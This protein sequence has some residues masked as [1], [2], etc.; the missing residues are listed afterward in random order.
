MNTRY[1]PIRRQELGDTAIELVEEV[2]IRRFSALTREEVRSM[3]QLE[4]L[5]KTRVWQ[6][7]H[8]EGVEKGIA[9][10]TQKAKADMARK[11]L[12]K[13]MSAMK[14]PSC[15]TS[16]RKRCDAWRRPRRSERNR[17]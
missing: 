1:P 9:K 12:A 6:E 17:R 16:H 4:D 8:G 5:R 11:C 3:F 15:W 7:A 14:S 13:G 2:L 10:G